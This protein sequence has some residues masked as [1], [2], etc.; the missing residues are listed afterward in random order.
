MQMKL[1]VVVALGQLKNIVVNCATN[2]WC[3]SI[4]RLD[5]KENATFS[6]NVH[7]PF[8]SEAQDVHKQHCKA[9]TF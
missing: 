3:N 4:D 6:C 1:T 9:K 5:A 8:D 7:C 2:S